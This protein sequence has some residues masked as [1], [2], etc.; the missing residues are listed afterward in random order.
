[1]QLDPAGL[2]PG[3]YV[4]L[5]RAWDDTEVQGDRHPWVLKDEHGLLESE[6][7]WLLQVR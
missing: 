4:V 5:C 6:R 3:R 1:L 7:R 2:E